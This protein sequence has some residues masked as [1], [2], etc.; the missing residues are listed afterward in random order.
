MFRP[1]HSTAARSGY[2]FDPDLSAINSSRARTEQRHTAASTPYL[3]ERYP[4]AVPCPGPCA[5]CVALSSR[6]HGH[7]C[8][9]HNEDPR[10][11]PYDRDVMR[12]VSHGFVKP[13]PEFDPHH[14]HSE[15]DPPGFSRRGRPYHRPSSYDAA[16]EELEFDR[17][18][19]F[20]H[21]TLPRFDSANGD[22]CFDDDVRG[23]YPRYESPS[24]SPSLLSLFGASVGP[25]S[26]VSRSQDC[27][28]RNTNLDRAIR[29]ISLERGSMGLPPGIYPDYADLERRKNRGRGIIGAPLGNYP[30][31]A[32][33]L[34]AKDHDSRRAGARPA[35][36][37]LTRHRFEDDSEADDLED[38][39]S[40][41]FIHGPHLARPQGHHSDSDVGSIDTDSEEEYF[42]QIRDFDFV[43]DTIADSYTGR[44][45]APTAAEKTHRRYL[46][47]LRKEYATEHLRAEHAQAELRRQ[48]RHDTHVA[49]SDI[50]DDS[51]PERVA[52]HVRN[53]YSSGRRRAAADYITGNRKPSPRGR[54]NDQRSDSESITPQPQNTHPQ[55]RPRFA[56]H[57]T[58]TNRNPSSH[59]THK[60]PTQPRRAPNRQTLPQKPHSNNNIALP[61]D[62]A[63]PSY[64]S[65]PPAHVTNS[66]QP[67]PVS[68][69]PSSPLATAVTETTKP[70]TTKA[71]PLN[72]AQNPATPQSNNN[73]TPRIAAGPTQLSNKLDGAFPPPAVRTPP[74]NKLH[75]SPAELGTSNHSDSSDS[76]AATPMTSS[77]N[78]DDDITLESAGGSLRGI[79]HNMLR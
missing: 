79:F 67:D 63:P 51:I 77:D 39:L 3:P 28:N 57:P 21:Y 62:Q 16:G 46:V 76:G 52:R 5:C 66:V 23:E 13:E 64:D 42:R 69:T 38:N 26:P 43:D 49:Q 45:R 50:E 71:G 48:K 75:T 32:A 37:H 44:F 33:F 35:G 27:E 55:V 36:R 70:N 6:T 61:K 19:R 10:Y 8:H 17:H 73:I 47:S 34:P 30:D 54:R 58:T 41:A 20:G 15:V 22:S 9:E 78:D 12:H 68:N 56:A 14:Q 18:G 31:Y 74:F 72:H 40:E 11:S 2:V 24:E 60:N 59:R 7:G 4:V 29:F 25:P 65:V 53:T 1:S